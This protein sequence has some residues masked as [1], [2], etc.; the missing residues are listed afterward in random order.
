MLKIIYFLFLLLES[1]IT[2]LIK[3]QVASIRDLD[4][5]NVIKCQNDVS[6]LFGI[7]LLMMRNEEAIK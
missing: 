2:F 5:K 3:S 4:V 1:S 7:I 6:L